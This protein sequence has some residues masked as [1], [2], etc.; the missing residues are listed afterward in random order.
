MYLFGKGINIETT[1]TESQWS[2]ILFNFMIRCPPTTGHEVFEHARGVVPPST[3]K[4]MHLKG[5]DGDRRRALRILVQRQR[6]VGLH[7]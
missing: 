5:Q 1:C 3:A 4:A 6:A 7:I 2:L